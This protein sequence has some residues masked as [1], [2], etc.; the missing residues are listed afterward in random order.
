MSKEKSRTK[1]S[2]KKYTIELTPLSGLLWVV[3]LFFLLSWIFVLGILV[4]RGSLPETVTTMADLR[5]QIDKLQEIVRHKDLQDQNMN[6]ELE[7]DPKLAFYEK[8]S[9][10]KEEV[11]EASHIS[12]HT[13]THGVK[14]EKVVLEKKETVQSSFDRENDIE[15]ISPDKDKVPEISDS[16]KKFTIQIASLG[17]R[18]KA[19]K[20][21]NELTEKGYPVYYYE[22]NV[23]NR[24][25]FRIRCGKFETREEAQEY[26]KRLVNEEGIKGF[27]SR[28]E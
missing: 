9:S 7:S 24:T 20:L 8:L 28:F 16:D 15:K 21:V 13:D 19:E 4:G 5:G 27:V 26:S 2:I 18:D 12:D 1:N 23:D 11:K 25:F 22:A 3:L 17:E 14:E 6:K 10:K